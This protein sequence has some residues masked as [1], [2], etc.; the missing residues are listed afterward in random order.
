MHSS[1]KNVASCSWNSKMSW[2]TKIHH[3][4]AWLHICLSYWA[5]Y[6]FL[7]LW[8]RYLDVHQ[9]GSL[10]TW[11]ARKASS[12]EVVP[13][14]AGR[15]GRC[16]SYFNQSVEGFQRPWSLQ[17]LLQSSS[18]TCSTGVL[19]LPWHSGNWAQRAS[20]QIAWFKDKGHLWGESPLSCT[21]KFTYLTAALIDVWA[22]LRHREVPAEGIINVQTHTLTCLKV[23][24][25]IAIL[26]KAF[27]LM[28]A[29]QFC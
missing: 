7:V 21:Q 15:I 20:Q 12:E 22:A 13:H 18:E 29:G 5:F 16:S 2:L 6:F 1:L 24:V 25:G 11:F 9:R 14:A 19:I 28:A 10:H 26:Q 8:N 17:K 4:A 27:T 23:R 3:L